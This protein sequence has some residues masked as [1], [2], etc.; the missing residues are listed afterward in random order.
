VGAII[1]PSFGALKNWLQEQ[2]IPFTTNADII[3]HP[4]VLAKYQAL[5]D[6]YNQYFNHVEQVKK[7][8]LLPAEWSIETGEMTPKLSLKRKV[9]LEKFKAEIE[10][11]YNS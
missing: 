5:I 2:Q 4:K 8:T 9:V 1:V 3:K 11:I 7:F 6:E 10:A